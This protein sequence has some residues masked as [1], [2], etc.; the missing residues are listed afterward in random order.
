[1]TGEVGV[2]QSYLFGLR[3]LANSARRRDRSNEEQRDQGLRVLATFDHSSAEGCK[4]HKP[5]MMRA[6]VQRYRGARLSEHLYNLTVITASGSRT[7]SKKAEQR[8]NQA[9]RPKEYCP[10]DL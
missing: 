3:A 8:I 9:S 1:M 10:L 4:H 6:R 2:N 5:L 7:L